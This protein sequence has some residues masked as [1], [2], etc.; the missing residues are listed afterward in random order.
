LKIRAE[1]IPYTLEFILPAGTSRG[2]LERKPAWFI[3][4]TD[5]HGTTGLGEVSFIPGLSPGGPEDV[6]VALEQVC[7]RISRGETDPRESPHLH[8][9]I[10]FA[11]DTALRDLESGGSR[12]LYPSEFTEGHR[13]IPT[14]GLIWMGERPFLLE[15]VRARIEQGFRVLKMKVGAMDFGVETGVL[16][17]I[18]EEFG[19]ADLEIRLDANGA[20]T[21]EEA[22]RKMEILAAY[23]IHSMEQPLAPGQWDEMAVLCRDAPVPV[24]LDEE[25]AGIPKIQERRRLLNRVRPG[26]LIL[27]PGLLGGFREAEQWIKLAGEYGAGWWVTSALESNIGL[28]ALAQWTWQ[29]GVSVPQGLGTGSLYRNNIPSPLRMEGELLWYRGEHPWDLGPMQW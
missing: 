4:L 12:I 29:R 18:R 6:E 3:R 11:L 19:T 17:W 13:G 23:G 16:E 15:Q 20:W 24:A 10:R 21:P 2:V 9:G 14:N 26:Y 7:R 22:M 8:P 28:N 1:Y 27:K 25:L 5:A